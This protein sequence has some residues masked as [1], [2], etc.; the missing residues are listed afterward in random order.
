MKNKFK[1]VAKVILIII[2]LTTTIKAQEITI[3]NWYEMLS[4]VEPGETTPKYIN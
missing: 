4:L 1:E 3:A 2:F